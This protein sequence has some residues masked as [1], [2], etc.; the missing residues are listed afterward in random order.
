MP[1]RAAAPLARICCALSPRANGRALLHALPP[2][3]H[4]RAC[5]PASPRPGNAASRCDPASSR[6]PACRREPPWPRLRAAAP[7]LQ[8][9]SERGSVHLGGVL[10]CVL[11][12]VV[13]CGIS[14]YLW[15]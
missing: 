13:L 3:S 10:E 7:R 1:A 2:V 4:S 8:K 6:Q 12:V 15:P 14:R 11:E 9:T 5:R